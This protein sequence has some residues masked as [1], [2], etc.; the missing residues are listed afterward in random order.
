[1]ILSSLRRLPW[2]FA[3]SAFILLLDRITKSW[4]VA[5]VRMGEAIPVVPHILRITHYSNFGGNFGIFAESTQKSAFAHWGLIGLNSLIPLVLVVV[6]VRWANRFTLASIG[7]ALALG[8]TLGNLHDRF[9]YGSVVDFIE[10]HIFGYHW[11]DFNVA[12]MAYIA[13][14]CLLLFDT[15][16]WKKA[17]TLS[18]I[19]SSEN[20]QANQQERV[21]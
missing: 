15:R 20:I 19:L 18:T 13:G 4:V 10:L 12:D 11:P 1:M 7:L 2:L 5:R 9:A 16:T 3:I 21:L 14:F 8:G 6:M 17:A